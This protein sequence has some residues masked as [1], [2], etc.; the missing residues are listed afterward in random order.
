[1]DN[2]QLLGILTLENM[3]DPLSENIWQYNKMAGTVRDLIDTAENI[4][5]EKYLVSK[6]KL[7]A[8]DIENSHSDDMIRSGNSW[9][10]WKDATQKERTVALEEDKKRIQD[11][12][13]KHPI[14]VMGD[15]NKPMAILDGNHRVLKAHELKKKTI[16]T[17][18][19]SEE[20][21]QTRFGSS[22]YLSK[23]WS[24][25]L[26]NSDNQKN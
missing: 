21:V 25:R 23:L 12:N 9:V 24:Y 19:V 22:T 5:A 8:H 15:N 14:I 7:I 4:K 17:K 20:V 2:P 6:L 13:F 18:F 26:A 11:A 16:N 10:K 3:F 1:M